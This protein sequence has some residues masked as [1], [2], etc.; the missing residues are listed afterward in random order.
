MRTIP[1][2]CLMTLLLSA[3]LGKSEPGATVTPALLATSTPLVPAGTATS[4]PNLTAT[5]DWEQFQATLEALKTQVASVPTSAPT[6][7]DIP[8]PTTRPMPTAG[9]PLSVA[10][11]RASVDG[12]RVVAK[13]F[14]EDIHYADGYFVVLKHL[15]IIP[16]YSL[17]VVFDQEIS[18]GLSLGPKIPYFYARAANQRSYLTYDEFIKAVGEPS[19]TPIDYIYQNFLDLQAAYYYL[20]S[21]RT[22]NTSDGFFQFIILGILAGQLNN[23]LHDLYNDTIVMCNQSDI[24]LAAS[25]VRKF[26][27]RYKID[28]SLPDQVMQDA[29][30]LSLEPVVELGKDTATVRIVTFTKWGGFIETK[31]EL[32]R[33]FPHKLLGEWHQNLIPYDCGVI[34]Q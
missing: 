4:T 27:E 14:T 34:Y 13:S 24:D 17:D 9:T 7:T 23:G 2:I 16:G 11:C 15:S 31:Y 8:M 29:R 19:Y 3:C 32:T 26:N 18:D 10:D 20:N 30:K 33:T 25:E 12:M 28:L 5:R 21:I 22:D 1:L 6:L